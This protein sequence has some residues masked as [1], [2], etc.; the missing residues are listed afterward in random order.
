MRTSSQF[1][2]S[3]F[4]AVF[5]ITVAEHW[6]AAMLYRL[7][8]TTAGHNG[9]HAPL[10]FSVPF[11]LGGALLALAS[12][13]IYWRLRSRNTRPQSFYQKSIRYTFLMLA[14]FAA[15]T[16]AIAG[17]QSLAA[18]LRL[19]DRPAAILVIGI[20]LLAVGTWWYDHNREEFQTY[21]T[22]R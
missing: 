2:V 20:F 5:G 16:A 1:P 19:Q 11:T 6:I 21:R 10:R 3:V 15:L 7:I 13:W 8:A 17:E 12:A 9:A 22:V 4:V 14:L 18:V